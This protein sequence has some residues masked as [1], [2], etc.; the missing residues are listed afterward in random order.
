MLSTDLDVLPLVAGFSGIRTKYGALLPPGARC[1]FLRSTGVQNNDPPE[2]VDA[3]MCTTLAQAL[4][5]CR[6]GFGD[7]IYALPGHSEN[8]TTTPTFVAGVRIIGAGHGTNR[9]VFRWTATT[10]Q[11]AISVA[12]VI[13]SGIKMRWE[14]A[15]VVKALSVTGSYFFLEGCEIETASGA[16]NYAALG[17]SFGT[18]A[19]W[20]TVANCRFRGN[21]ATAVTSMIETTGTAQKGLRIMNTHMVGPGHTTHGLISIGNP[22]TEMFFENLRLYN[23]TASSTTTIELTAAASDGL[24]VGIDS[25]DKNNGTATAQG[26][27]FGAG[28]LVECSRTAEVN[29]PAKNSIA[30]PA[31]GT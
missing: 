23:T 5:Q 8:V 31:A 28:S 27:T 16:S 26:I 7:T 30:S 25:A 15:V 20:A 9:P 14:G 13:I 12:D 6:A 18:G 1:V 19:D 24:F 4:L 21:T 3:G 11:W 29:E 22:A 10:S 17:L 2:I